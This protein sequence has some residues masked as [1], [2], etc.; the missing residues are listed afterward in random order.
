M[1]PTGPLRVTCT[2]WVLTACHFGQVFFPAGETLRS[3]RK[4][5]AYQRCEVRVYFQR[6]ISQLSMARR[7]CDAQPD[8]EKT[9]WLTRSP[10]R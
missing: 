9:A 3:R 10:V 1:Y 7:D 2:S 6:V 8:A 4:K 5:L